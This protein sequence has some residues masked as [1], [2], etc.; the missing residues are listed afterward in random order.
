MNAPKNHRPSHRARIN[1]SGTA[2]DC[3][4]AAKI[5][6]SRVSEVVEAFLQALARTGC[7]ADT[8]LAQHSI[9]VQFEVN[10]GDC[11]MSR[12]SEYQLRHSIC[13][14]NYCLESQGRVRALLYHLFAWAKEG[15]YLP[16][17]EPTAADRLDRLERAKDIC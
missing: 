12:V 6:K 16:S 9:L 7:P 2:R 14:R 4:L 15:D 8:L 10:V 1:A 5:F 13:F 3:Q 17:D 11:A